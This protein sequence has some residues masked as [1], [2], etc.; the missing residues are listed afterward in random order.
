[1]LVINHLNALQQTS[2]GEHERWKITVSDGWLVPGLNQAAQM[3]LKAGIQFDLRVAASIG[4][5]TI[6]DVRIAQPID[7]SPFMDVAAHDQRGLAT[8]DEFS[9]GGAA[10]VIAMSRAVQRRPVRRRVR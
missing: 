8:V 1:M 2:G 4:R 3:D 7:T 10:D 6:D 5:T 9:Y